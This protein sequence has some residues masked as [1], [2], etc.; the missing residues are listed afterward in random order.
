MSFGVPSFLAKNVDFSSAHACYGYVPTCWGLG[1]LDGDLQEIIEGMAKQT[2]ERLLCCQS[3]LKVRPERLMY[4]LC[5]KRGEK[6]T[7]KLINRAVK[8]NFKNQKNL[9]WSEN[10]PGRRMAWGLCV[11]TKKAKIIMIHYHFTV[12]WETQVER[13]YCWRKHSRFVMS[14]ASVYRNWFVFG[15][16]SWWNRGGETFFVL[17]FFYVEIF[18][19]WVY[20]VRGMANQSFL[21][22]CI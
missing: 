11:A 16:R 7:G 12:M 14:F 1:N 22:V 6:G 13:R 15:W 2:D 4:I 21:F 18:G 17:C 20:H 5:K 10:H 9:F 8:K 3:N 19:C